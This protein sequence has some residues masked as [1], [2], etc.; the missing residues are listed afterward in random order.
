MDNRKIRSHCL[1]KKC[2]YRSIGMLRFMFL[3]QF[4][5]GGPLDFVTLPVALNVS[6]DMWGLS[7][8]GTQPQPHCETNP[9]QVRQFSTILEWWTC[10]DEQDFCSKIQLMSD[11]FTEKNLGSK[12][13]DGTK[14]P[15]ETLEITRWSVFFYIGLW[16]NHAVCHRLKKTCS[17]STP[18]YL[19]VI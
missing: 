11:L 5:F 13:I 14:K 4:L 17:L 9:L 8:R 1:W 3:P 18:R 7:I 19:V 10:F 16:L 12:K 15:I 6:T 2:P